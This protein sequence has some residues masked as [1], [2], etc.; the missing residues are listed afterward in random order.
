VP[1]IITLQSYAGLLPNQG[2]CKVIFGVQACQYDAHL[3]GVN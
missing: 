3:R 2:R 1:V